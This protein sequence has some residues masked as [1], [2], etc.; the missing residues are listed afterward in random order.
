MKRH[1]KKEVT[2]RFNYRKK[3]TKHTKYKNGH[4]CYPK[5]TIAPEHVLLEK[6]NPNISH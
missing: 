5:S 3:K 1:E 2:K 4:H 6:I